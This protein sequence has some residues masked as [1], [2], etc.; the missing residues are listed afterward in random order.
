MVGVI[1]GVLV[2]G[3]GVFVGGSGVLVGGNGVLVGGNG[4]LVGGK[5]VLVGG[6][7][8][9]VGGKGVLVGGNGVFVGG[10]GVLVG[11]NGVKVGGSV[12]ADVFVEVGVGGNDSLLLAITM[13]SKQRPLKFLSFKASV[14]KRTVSNS[15]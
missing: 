3:N 1:V 5:G 13:L 11:G 15:T 9:L 10:K 2:G 6:N 7:G 14:T 8:V 4:V 12:G